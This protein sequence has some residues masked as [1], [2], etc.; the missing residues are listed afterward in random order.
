MFVLTGDYVIAISPFESSKKGDEVKY[1]G[2]IHEVKGDRVLLRFAESF[3]AKYSNED[4]K[5]TFYFSRTPLRKEHH[6][7]ELVKKKIPFILFPNK[8]ISNERQVDVNLNLENGELRRDN[9]IVPW[10]NSSLNI[11]QKQAVT[12]I[13]QGVARP[14][15]YVIFGPPG[16]NRKINL[17]D[18]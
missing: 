10:Y 2:V 1:E 17:Q 3:H 8:I 11:V 5:I 12:N 18:I 16:K 6:A 15:P 14:L 13:L 4:Y 7:V 9:E